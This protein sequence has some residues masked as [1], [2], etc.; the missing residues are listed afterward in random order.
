MNQKKLRNEKNA[1][2]KYNENNYVD[3]EVKHDEHAVCTKKY[4]W[5][6]KI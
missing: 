5:S 4:C 6:Q 2:D 1:K 3:T